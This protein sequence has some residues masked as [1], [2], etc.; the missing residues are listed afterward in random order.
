MPFSLPLVPAP[1]LCYAFLNIY[2]Y[3]GVFLMS[4]NKQVSETHLLGLLL[5]V[6]GGFLD[7]YTYLCRGRVFANAQTGNIVLLGVNLT[8]QNWNRAFYYLM[9]ILAFVAGILVCEIIQ[10]HFK[11][12]KKFH[13]RQLIVLMEIFCLIIAGFLPAPA[14]DTPVN[15]MISFVCALQVEAF[16]KMNGNTYATTMCTG[17]LRSASQQLYLYATTKQKVCLHNCLQYYNVILFFIIGAGAGSF[18]TGIFHTK[19]VWLCAL[20]LLAAFIA[21]FLNREESL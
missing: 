12:K 8:E 5:A 7:A 9:P 4:R 19:A 14:L 10:T 13:W 18:F 2:I 3:K 21:M 16:R 20:G 15:I 1:F 6:V 17:N 11:W